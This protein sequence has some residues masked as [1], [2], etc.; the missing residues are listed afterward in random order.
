MSDHHFAG[1]DFDLPPLAVDIVVILKTYRTS[2]LGL[3]IGLLVMSKRR[4][5]P[6]LPRIPRETLRPNVL[7]FKPAEAVS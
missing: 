2:S 6:K 3:L 5:R 7:P 1:E 4:G